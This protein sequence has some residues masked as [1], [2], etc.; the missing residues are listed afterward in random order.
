MQAAEEIRTLRDVLIELTGQGLLDQQAMSRIEQHLAKD[1]VHDSEPWFVKLLMAIGAW[2]AAICFVA[3]LPSVGLV[4]G[5]ASI[6]FWAVAFLGVAT[7]LRRRTQHVFLLQLALALSVVGHC[8]ALVGATTLATSY[9]GHFA[10]VA[11]AAIILCLVLYPLY[12]DSLHRF[13]SC[14]LAAGC[15]TAWIVESQVWQ[16]IHVD[17]LTKIVA[18]GI[19][20]M[21]RTDLRMLRPL[22][23]AMAISMPASLFLVLLNVGVSEDAFAAL[24]WPANIIL[25]VTLIWLYQRVVGGWEQLRS[26]PLMLAVGATVCLASF[27]TPGVLAALGLMV[28]GY[29]RGDRY[30]LGIGVAFF[31]VFIVVF[32]YEWQIS[33]LVK[34]WIMAGSGAVLLS[35]RWLLSLRTWAKE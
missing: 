16:L 4:Y 21:Y 31:P 15:L 28:L 7:S 1:S 30:L 17:M 34:S 13:L 22:G 6:V 5:R 19:V 23:Y 9:T 3:C 14:L 29:A 33:L 8:L 11:A 12:C 24:W 18:I 25:A 10:A 20:F 2:V 32:Y 35:A 26:E 27:T